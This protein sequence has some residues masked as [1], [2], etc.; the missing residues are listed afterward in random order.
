MIN[1][2]KKNF[3]DAP[4]VI[5]IQYIGVHDCELAKITSNEVLLYALANADND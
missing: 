3:L 2:L 5:P 1:H 4:D